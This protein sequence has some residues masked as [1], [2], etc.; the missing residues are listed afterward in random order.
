MG[1]N[2]RDFLKLT[3]AGAAGAAVTGEAVALQRDPLE[4]PPE[5]VGMLYDSTLCIGCKA[6]MVAC[7]QAND[8][9]PDFRTPE[10]VTWEQ[11]VKI[12]TANVERVKS[13][14]SAVLP[15]VDFE[16]CPCRTAIDQA[17]V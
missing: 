9:P 11:I 17:L 6:C 12:M 7:K 2:R 3:A 1:L 5:A 13:L 4:M 16:D 14:L 10:N 8:M 15:A